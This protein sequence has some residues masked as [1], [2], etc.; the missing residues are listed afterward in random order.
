MSKKVTTTLV[1]G[2][3]VGTVRT[4]SGGRFEEDLWECVYVHGLGFRLRGA[5][6]SKI[7]EADNTNSRAKHTSLYIGDLHGILHVIDSIISL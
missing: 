1:G 5:W 3:C 4:I 6:A 2:K 7:S